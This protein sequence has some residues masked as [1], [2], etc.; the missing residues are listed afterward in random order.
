MFTLKLSEFSNAIGK[1]DAW[2]SWITLLSFFWTMCLC[3]IKFLIKET[4]LLVT[5]FSKHWKDSPISK[6]KKKNLGEP[7]TGSQYHQLKPPI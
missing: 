6:K 1:T 3:Y 7:L 2:L 4:I 5:F